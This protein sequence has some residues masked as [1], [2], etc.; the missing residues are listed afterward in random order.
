MEKKNILMSCLALLLA[1]G[2]VAGMPLKARACGGGDGMD[3]SGMDHGSYG[4]MNQ[5]Y[6]GQ[7]YSGHMGQGQM[8]PAVMGGPGAPAGTWS[9]P[10]APGSSGSGHMGSTGSMDHSQ[11]GHGGASR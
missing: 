10:A 7:G 6:G 5:G 9:E 11:M 2:L 4:H 8:G 1:A 3:H